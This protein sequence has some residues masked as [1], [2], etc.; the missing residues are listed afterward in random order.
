VQ[1]PHFQHVDMPANPEAHWSPLPRA[2]LEW[3][4]V[5]WAWLI[6]QIIAHWAIELSVQEWC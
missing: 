1:E 5:R 2:L 6:D 4:F 3:D